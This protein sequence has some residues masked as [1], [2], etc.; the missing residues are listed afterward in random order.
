MS[1]Y[2]GILGLSI[3][4]ANKSS[5]FIDSLYNKGL[6]SYRFFALYLTEVGSS[7]VLMMG[8]YD[9]KYLKNKDDTIYVHKLPNNN[10]FALNLVK[11][12]FSNQTLV[13]NSTANST[14]TKAYFNTRYPY[15]GLPSDSF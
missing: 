13:D 8:D 10:E 9:T 7:S 3:S 2:D 4:S 15:I 14:T 11:L 1:T 6:I 5:S 12:T